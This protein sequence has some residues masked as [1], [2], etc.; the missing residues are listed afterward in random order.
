MLGATLLLLPYRYFC[1]GVRYRVLQFGLSL[2][3]ATMVL[4]AGK[5]AFGYLQGR[6]S[7]HIIPVMGIAVAVPA[8]NLW[9]L[10]KIRQRRTRAA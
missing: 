1:V 8:S 9:A 3:V 7:W 5:G 2:L 6:K 4:F 10:R